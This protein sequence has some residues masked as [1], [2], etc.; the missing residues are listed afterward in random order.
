MNKR[1]FYTAARNPDYLE[2]SP[3]RAI[4]PAISKVRY[5]LRD[6]S[7]MEDDGAYSGTAGILTKPIA[8]EVESW[9]ATPEARQKTLRNIL[10]YAAVQTALM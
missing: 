5:F 6:D 9:L 3:L 4:S 7:A 8:R 10:I 1:K 2:S